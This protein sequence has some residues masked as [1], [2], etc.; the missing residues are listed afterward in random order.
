MPAAQN[1]SMIKNSSEGAKQTLQK[2]RPSNTWALQCLQIL[3]FWVCKFLSLRNKTSRKVRL[4][5]GAI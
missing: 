1:F 4:K 5:G 2:N 3:R